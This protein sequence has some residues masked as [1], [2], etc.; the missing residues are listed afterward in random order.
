MSYCLAS[1]PGE[2]KKLSENLVAMKETLWLEHNR[3]EHVMNNAEEE[4][5]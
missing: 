2:N 4:L 3:A 5:A 1:P